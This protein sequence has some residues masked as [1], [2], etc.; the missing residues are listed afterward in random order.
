MKSWM[1]GWLRVW[2]FVPWTARQPKNKMLLGGIMA[3]IAGT[4]RLEPLEASMRW[5]APLS[6]CHTRVTTVIPRSTRSP[7]DS[8]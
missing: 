4:R 6:T 7:K 5:T 1:D 8:P 3:M 2:A